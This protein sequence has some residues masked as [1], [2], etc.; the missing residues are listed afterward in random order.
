MNI[1]FSEQELSAL[2]GLVGQ[3]QVR[4]AAPGSIEQNAFFHQL[5]RKL[6]D[7]LQVAREKID[8]PLASAAEKKS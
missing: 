2:Y 3:V 7:C 6:E 8:L 1:E 4:S 5:A